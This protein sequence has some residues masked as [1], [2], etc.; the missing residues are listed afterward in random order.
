MTS[1]EKPKKPTIYFVAPQIKAAGNGSPGQT[2]HG[3]FTFENDTVV[4]CHPISGE[5]ARDPQGKT[6]TFK[7]EPPTNTIEDARIHA[8]RLTLD[9]RQALRGGR[10]KGFG[11]RGPIGGPKGPLNY[12]GTGWM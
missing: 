12:P 4:I 10:P 6:Y 9:F 3:A 5:P 1:E 2:T 8:R 11:G 7:L